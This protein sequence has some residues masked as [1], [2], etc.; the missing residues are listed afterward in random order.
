MYTYYRHTKHLLYKQQ[1]EQKKVFRKSYF[2][3]TTGGMKNV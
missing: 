1:G 2:K 3:D